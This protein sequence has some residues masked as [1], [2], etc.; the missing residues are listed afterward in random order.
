MGRRGRKITVVGV[1]ARP[2]LPL[3]PLVDEVILV[4]NAE[5]RAKA[6]PATAQTQ[7]SW[8]DRRG[9]S[10]RRKLNSRHHRGRVMLV[11]PFW[12]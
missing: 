3:R 11:G 9:A 4:R 5:R 7:A 6:H 10:S 12:I 2:P 1:G 8:A